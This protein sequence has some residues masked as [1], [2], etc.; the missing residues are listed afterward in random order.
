MLHELVL[1][2]LI[3]GGA[4][5]Y[6]S[7]VHEAV[8]YVRDFRPSELCLVLA[9]S[10]KSEGFMDSGYL[11]LYSKRPFGN[12]GAAFAFTLASMAVLTASGLFCLDEVRRER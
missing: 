12:E 9:S 2:F 7:L 5:F 10:I 11:A 1:I 3:A 6:S 4:M 8:H